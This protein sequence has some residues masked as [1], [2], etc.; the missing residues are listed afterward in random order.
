[1]TDVITASEININEIAE[2]P[3]SFEVP[4]LSVVIPTYGVKGIEL[5]RNCITTLYKTHAHLMPEALVVSDGDD[6]A[7]L[8]ALKSMAAELHFGLIRIDRH[9]FA[10]ACNAG[11]RMANGQMG[12]FLLNNDLEFETPALQI[13]TDAMVTAGAGV[14]GCRLLYPD[15]TI[16]HAGVVFVSAPPGSGVPGYFDH[17]L[18]FQEE[19]HIDA[20]VMRRGLVTGACLGIS[21]DFIERSGYLD[22][23]FGFTCE[24]VDLNLRAFECGLPPIYCGYVS[25]LHL[26]G[27]SRGKTLEE[28]M[29]LEPEIAAKEQASLRFLF[30]K[31]VGLDFSRFSV[32][33][34]RVE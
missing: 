30:T 23:R 25:V 29:K 7:V 22:E 17:Y 34:Q 15:R 8:E 13:L 4:W 24:D 33:D 14:I 10:A 5:T 21:R 9:G 19:N 2:Q 28:K 27:A 6:G 11:I 12:C 31:Y 16:Q 32:R 26:E 3:K 18:R 20:V 1:M